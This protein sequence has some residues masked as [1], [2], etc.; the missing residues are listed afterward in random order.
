MSQLI[1]ATRIAHL[2]VAVLTADGKFLL[3]ILAG[4]ADLDGTNCRP[5]IALLMAETGWARSKVFEVLAH[6][7]AIGAIVP[8]T[9]AAWARSAG[10]AMEFLVTIGH[11][12]GT[13]KPPRRRPGRPETTSAGSDE[14]IDK[15]RP[16]AR[17][18]LDRNHVRPGGLPTSAVADLTEA[19]LPK[20]GR[21]GED[22]TTPPPASPSGVE[23]RPDPTKAIRALL[24][25]HDFATSPDAVEEWVEW[26]RAKRFRR[27]ESAADFM[28]WS[29]AAHR[30]RTGQRA[31]YLRDVQDA[32]AP[33]NAVAI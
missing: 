13:T 15:P 19:I 30:A 1:L 11:L 31:K 33:W 9:S 7:R 4:F 20:P 6:L 14:V 25:Q 2:D 16:P 29:Q 27:T 24:V 21:G 3:G 5:G 17:T 32:Y 22:P 8:L 28:A 18:R 23:T 10:K 26:M 12:P